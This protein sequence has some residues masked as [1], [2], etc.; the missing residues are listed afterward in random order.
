MKKIINFFKKNSWIWIIVVVLI[1]II[2]DVYLQRVLNPEVTSTPTP[3]PKIASYKSVIPGVS[4]EDFLNEV[5]GTPVKTTID[6]NKLLNE[7]K[8]T[9]ELRFHS[10]VIENGRVI[11]IKEIV[12]SRDSTKASSVMESYNSAPNTLYSKSSNASF[13]L[14]VY[15]TN[16]IAYLGHKDG[17]LL[18]IWYFEPTTIGNFLNTWGSDYSTQPSQEILQ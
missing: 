9:S 12:S 14:Y 8:S 4:T 10:A 18:E 16:G 6:G 5:L 2:G 11:F 17:T 13:D 7:Y 1:A 15:P 3:V